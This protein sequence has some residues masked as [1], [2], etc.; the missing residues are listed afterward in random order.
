MRESEVYR[1]VGA[2]CESTQTSCQ[3]SQ[4][5]DNPLST[6]VPAEAVTGVKSVFHKPNRH[7][8]S[9]LHP[10]R[11]PR[12][13]GAKQPTEG[14]KATVS[15]VSQEGTSCCGNKQPRLPAA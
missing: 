13:T 3:G 2:V 7:E 4:Q 11:K 14:H 1:T 6:Q 8:M 9:S 12:S 5:T 15:P 10:V